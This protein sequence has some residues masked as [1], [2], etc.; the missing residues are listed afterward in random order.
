L[1]HFFPDPAA[2]RAFRTLQAETGLMIFGKAAYDFLARASFSRSDTRAAVM[3]LYVDKPYASLVNDFF[4][5]AGYEVEMRE[6]ELVF[7]KKGKN[8]H[9]IHKVTHQAY[10]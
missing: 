10:T 8:D 1:Q 4:T 5:G 6:H 2:V 9:Y 3:S 7:L